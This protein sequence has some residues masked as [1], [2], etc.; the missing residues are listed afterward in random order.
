MCLG[1]GIIN[2]LALNYITKPVDLLVRRASPAVSTTQH[3]TEDFTKPYNYFIESIGRRPSH[4]LQEALL[5][6]TDR[7]KRYVSQNLVIATTA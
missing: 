2:H 7:A 5:P 3:A 6:Q 4:K 1:A